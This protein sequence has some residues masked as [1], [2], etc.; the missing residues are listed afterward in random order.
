MLD[1]HIEVQGSKSQIGFM[2]LSFLTYKLLS[3][4]VISS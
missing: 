2:D 4:N 1:P 3:N